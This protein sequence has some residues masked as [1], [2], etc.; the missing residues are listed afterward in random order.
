ML[1]VTEGTFKETHIHVPGGKSLHRSGTG[2]QR[3]DIGLTAEC[4]SEERSV[5]AGVQEKLMFEVP[6]THQSECALH[7]SG[8]AC[9]M[10]HA[11]ERSTLEKHLTL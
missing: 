4:V 11:M 5:N 7:T 3:K 1:T 9:A 6:A 8:R 10:G 2:S